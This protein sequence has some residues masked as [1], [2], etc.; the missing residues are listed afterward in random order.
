MTQKIKVAK[1]ESKPGPRGGTLTTI[2]DDK[3][4]TYSGFLKELAGLA[5]GDTVEADIQVNGKFNNI[6]AVKRIEKSLA[7]APS[8]AIPPASAQ[9]KTECPSTRASIEVQTAAN[10]I[11]ALWV[12]DKLTKDDAEVKQLRAWLRSKLPG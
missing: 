12:A 9:D 2:W 3:N 4:A 5:A 10:N 8:T 1:I 11:T 7:P 6:T